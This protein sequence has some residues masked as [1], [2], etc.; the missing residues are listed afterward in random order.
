MGF[1]IADFIWIISLLK[2]FLYLL[3]WRSLNIIIV[4]LFCWKQFSFHLIYFYRNPIHFIFQ[5]KCSF[6]HHYDVFKSILWELVRRSNFTWSKMLF[7][8]RLKDFATLVI[9]SKAVFFKRS[10]DST[11]WT[12][13]GQMIEVWNTLSIIWPGCYLIPWWNDQ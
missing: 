6:T 1:L 5:L 9:R 3:I 2:S 8:T 10:K 7:F 11:F 13:L 4:P 12:T